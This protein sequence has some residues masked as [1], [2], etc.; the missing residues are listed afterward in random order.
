MKTIALLFLVL[1]AIE[2]MVAKVQAVDP[3]PDYLPL[4]YARSMTNMG[5]IDPL[6]VPTMTISASNA[7]S[8]EL[9]GF[10]TRGILLTNAYY[11]PTNAP[12]SFDLPTKW[13]SSGSNGYVK[14]TF[15][16]FYNEVYYWLTNGD[17]IIPRFSTGSGKLS[18]NGIPQID[19]EA[20]P[21]SAV[22]LEVTYRLAPNPANTVWWFVRQFYINDSARVSY[23]ATNSVASPTTNP[24]GTFRL[25]LPSP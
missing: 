3:G 25:R 9:F 14:V 18:T 4:G 12:Y 7:V 13:V 19:F 17:K 10:D 1:T 20:P 6:S 2:A 22:N 11:D 21:N 16:V 15:D 8:V 5:G 24:M 23:L